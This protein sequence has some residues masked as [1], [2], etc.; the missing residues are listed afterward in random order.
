M[1]CIPEITAEFRERMYGILDLYAEPY[2]PLRP[3]IGI[4]E[5]PKQLLGDARKPVPMGPGRSE[6]YD[7]EYV[8]NGSANIF[9][10]VEF[11][12]GR[13]TA[14]VTC[15][16]TKKDFAKFVKHLADRVYPDA[17]VLRVVVDNLNTHNR[18]AFYETYGAE[19]AERI[20][21]R[22]EFHYTPKHASWLNVAEIEIAVMDAECTGRRIGDKNTLAKEVRAWMSRRNRQEKTID[23]RFTRQRADEKLSKY[24][25]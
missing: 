16:R 5:K 18:T 6:R 14:R 13:R 9:L 20:L 17:G 8:R 1:W 24:Y 12:A 19:E 25:V 3:V 15:R 21:G 4:D 23:W 22:I 11:K 10:A 7:Y 2:D